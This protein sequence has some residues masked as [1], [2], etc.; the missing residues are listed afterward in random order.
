MQKL[1]I[2]G[3]KELTGLIKVSGAKNSVV[4]LIPAAILSDEGVTIDN[5]PNISDTNALIDIL[6]LL[7]CKTTYK[8]ETLTID[9][10]NMNNITIP[11]ELSKK[12]RASYYFMGALLS[13][14]KK[15]EMY[16]PGGCNIGERPI[17]L[18]IKGFEELGAKVTIEEDKY[19]IEA[20]ELIGNKIYLDIA[21]VGATINIMLAASKA[22][23]TTIISNAA[24]E[25]EIVNVATLLNNMGAKVYGA[26]TSEITIKGIS[27]LGSA[28]I[29]V[30]PDRIEAAT[31]III[32]SLLGKDLVVSG[33]IK[34]HLDSLYY[35]LKDM[36][37]DIKITHNYAVLNASKDLKPIKI[38][39]TVFP[40]FVTDMGQPMQVLLTQATGNSIFEETIYENRMGHVPYLQKMGAKIEVSCN[41]IATING[42]TELHGEEVEATD[43]RAGAA[44]VIAGLIANGTTTIS[45]IGHILRGYE[46]IVSKLQGIGA[47]IEIIE[48]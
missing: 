1:K 35:K 5:I 34:E 6:K 26:G 23:G 8:D 4:A 14:Y 11:R 3:G 16:F 30:I 38:K 13:K 43:L 40:G 39:T 37:A 36:G 27:K 25:P 10:S 2:K 33:I 24:K 22:K 7:N 19:I 20:K 18:H 47:E 31:Y 46:N 32:G 44:M 41:R 42:P 48:E 29:E 21:S 28:Q 9:T 17:N 15:V 45:S 12:L